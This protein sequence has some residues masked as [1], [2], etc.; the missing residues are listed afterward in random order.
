MKTVESV[1]SKIEIGT[2]LSGSLSDILDQYKTEN[3]IVIVDENTHDFCLEFLINNFPALD[4]AEVILLPVGEENKVLEVC[5]QVWEA[6]SEF[7][8]SKNDL[9]INLGGGV[10]TDMGAF[11]ACLFK[12]GLN[13]LHIPTSLLA[14][15]DAS[16]GGKNGVDLNGFK[17]QLGLIKHPSHILIDPFFLTSLPEREIYNGYAEMLKHGLISSAELWKRLI[18]IKSDEELIAKDLIYE[19]VKIKVAIVDVDPEEKNIRKTLNFGHTIGHAI[20]SHFMDTTAIAHGHAVALGICG[21]AYLS[22]KKKMLSLEDYKQI[23]K[24]IKSNFPLIQFSDEDIKDVIERMRQD[25]KNTKGKISCVLL[26]AI[27]AAKYDCLLT[28]KEIGEALF[29]LNLL[30]SALN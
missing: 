2:L 18:E 30:A 8:F 25:K 3:I 9:V 13:F 23:E 15:V 11:I 12:R 27:G 4:R 10:V 5:F 17:N 20:E 24:I 29:H 14:M 28:D 26:T 7:N 6:F 22:M 1:H 16:I 19:V 21:E